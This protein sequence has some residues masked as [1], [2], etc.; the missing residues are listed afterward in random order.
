[1]LEGSDNRLS[2]VRPMHNCTKYRDELESRAA[3]LRLLKSREYTFCAVTPATH[4][5]V[6]ARPL[7]GPITLRDIFG[8]NRPFWETHVDPAL[9]E[10]LRE[11]DL[12][13]QGEG[14]MRSRVRVAS[15][16]NDLFVHSPFPTDDRDSVF[17][18]PDTYRFA[19]F[20]RGHLLHLAPKAIVDLGTGS[21]AGGIYARRCVPQ[22]DVTL[23]D[24]N[25]AALQ[26]ARANAVVAGIEVEFATSLKE[27]GRPDLVIANPPYIMDG[28]SRSYRDGGGLLGGQVA[29]DWAQEALEVL[30]PGGAMLLY[31]GASYV[32]GQAPLVWALRELARSEKAQIRVEELDP[33]VFGEELENPAYGEVERIA[34]FG[35]A[36]TKSGG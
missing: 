9:I 17:F 31:T 29:F 12:L 10:L 36:L 1:M 11:G 22:A 18:G 8:W 13:E 34:V 3:L 14:A 6:I 24:I 5:R 15:L 23:V 32:D 2:A 25:K 30:R 7:S 26:F 27:A 28:Q 19:N 16:E 4:A 33:D 20:L 21:G 35:I